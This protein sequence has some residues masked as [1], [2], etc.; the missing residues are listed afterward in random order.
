M[1]LDIPFPEYPRPQLKRDSYINLNGE[2]FLGHAKQGEPIE[3]QHKILVPYSPETKASGLGNFILQPNEVL[4][5]K[6]EFEIT[7]DFIKDIT[8]L[9]FGAVDYSCICY[10]NGKEVGFHQ[11]GFLPFTFNITKEIKIGKNEYDSL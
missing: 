8:F 5:Y 10:V 1:K 9:H 4:F 2:W 3:Y 7:S 6:R 11:G